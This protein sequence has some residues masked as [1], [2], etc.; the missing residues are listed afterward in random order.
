[1]EKIGWIG[2]GAMGA[3]MA[4]NLEK[5]GFPLSVY[6]RSP[7]KM[8][9]FR[10]RGVKTCNSIAEIIESCD[11]IFT[12]VSNDHSAKEV[13]QEIM[14]SGSLKGK[15]FIDMSTIS[16][17]L[18]I[19]ISARLLVK[20]AGFIDAPVAGSTVPAR[21][22]TLIILAGGQKADID[23]AQP[24]FEKLGKSVK[25]FGANGKGIAAKLSINYFI[26]VIYLG[27]SETVLFAEH[28]GISRVDI[29]DAIN[30]SA[31]G[32]GATRLKTPLIINRDFAPQFAL[33]LM[34]KDIGL[35]IENGMDMP[36]TNVLMQTYQDAQE[37][38]FGKQDVV[39]VIEFLNK[40]K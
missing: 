10:D 37:S 18:S 25:H 36:L 14:A 6:N 35:A 31:S 3:L 38:G 26:S 39:S 17:G 2:L 29:L 19:D 20:N 13:F 8:Q 40:E 15:L 34:L 1:M 23:R 12:M 16:E 30:E 27:L 28:N 21:E 33:E 9:P 7:D 24:Y 4:Y 11:I 5:A 22:G 32:S